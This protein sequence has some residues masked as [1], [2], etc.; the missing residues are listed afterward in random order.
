MVEF[1]DFHDYEDLETKKR[2]EGFIAAIKM[3]AGLLAEKREIAEVQKTLYDWWAMASSH[4][5][6]FIVSEMKMWVVPPEKRAEEKEEGKAEKEE[7]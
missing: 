3:V 1:D 5:G 2:L 6:D 7:V 4:L